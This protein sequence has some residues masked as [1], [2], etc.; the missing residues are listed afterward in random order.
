[1]GD[2]NYEYIGIVTKK[3]RLLTTEISAY[4]AKM[5]KRI[6]RLLKKEII[7][8]TIQLIIQ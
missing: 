4:T 8:Q 3:K 6:M 7:H 2:Y 5:R 1:M